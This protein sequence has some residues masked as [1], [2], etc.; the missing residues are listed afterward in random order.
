MLAPISMISRHANAYAKLAFF[1]NTFGSKMSSRQKYDMFFGNL[2]SL[3]TIDYKGKS[4]KTY[5]FNIYAFDSS[6]NS[7]S[8][9]YIVTHRVKNNNSGYTHTTIYIGQTDNLKERFSNHHKQGCF[10]RNNA[11]CLC[12]LLETNEQTRLSI[13]SD[14]LASHNTPCND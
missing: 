9:V 8:A 7:V 6:W 1:L 4:G 3:G 13:E 12:I 14:L 2:L 11:N 5:T 10:A